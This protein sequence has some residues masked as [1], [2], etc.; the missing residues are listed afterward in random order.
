MKE[1]GELEEEEETYR[2]LKPMKGW[3]KGDE[4]HRGP[5]PRSGKR[6]FVELIPYKVNGAKLRSKGGNNSH[7]YAAPGAGGVG[8]GVKSGK[9]PARAEGV[10]LPESTV[11]TPSE[12]EAEVASRLAAKTTGAVA[13]AAM[14]EAAK[15]VDEGKGVRERVAEC[16]RLRRER[17]TFGK[18]NIHGWGL[19]AKQFLKAGSMVVERGR[20]P[21]SQRGGP[22]GEG[23]RTHGHDVYLLAADDKTVIDTTVKGSIA[24]FTNHSCTPNMYTKLVALDGTLGYSSSPA[25]T[26]TQGRS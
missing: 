10:G 6:E 19:I 11:F 12:W 20:A 16:L 15:I 7:G 13:V 17:L 9:D 3:K 14:A 21:A 26:C 8:G 22:A 2:R 24:R 23:V 5:P 18:S 25:S 4:V 1:R